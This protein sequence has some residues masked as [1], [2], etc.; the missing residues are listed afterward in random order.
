M[1]P[2]Q[3]R[4]E[5]LDARTRH[6]LV[7]RRRLRDGH[8]PTAVSGCDDGRRLRRNFEPTRRTR[9]REIDRQRRRSSSHILDKALEKDR[10]LRYQS[11]REM[12]ADLARLK[13]DAASGST[14]AS[15]SVP[16]PKHAAEE[17]TA[18][19]VAAH[20]PPASWSSRWPRISR[21]DPAARRPRPAR[22]PTRA[23][24]HDIRRRPAGA[25]RRGRRTASSS[26]TART[27]RATSTS[28]SSRSV[29]AAPCA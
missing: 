14:G 8:R 27:S 12:R 24:A 23:D 9:R 29:A 5:P 17:E 10:E 18:R 4:G 13:R 20:R 16:S 15:K 3:V 7:R 26:R 25:A 11:I 21:G 28:G 6:L 22:A 2:E 19:V 1:S